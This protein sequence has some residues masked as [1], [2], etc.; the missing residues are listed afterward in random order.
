M[1]EETIEQQTLPPENTLPDGQEPAKDQSAAPS[2]EE[3]AREQGWN[4]DYT[5]PDRIDAAE[6]VRRK[7][8]FD[9][10]R[11]QSRELREIKQSV[12]AMAKTYKSMSEA[13]YRRGIA[14]AAKRMDEAE[15]TY[16]VGAY[17]EALKEKT[18][19]EAAQASV[20]HTIPEGLPPEVADF[21]NRNPWFDKDKI[22][23][24]DALEYKD[25]YIKRNP[26]APLKDVLLYVEERIKRDYPEKFTREKA[27]TSPPP[28]VPT[29]ETGGPS[30]PTTNDSLA[31]L[32]ASLTSEEKRV[33]KMFVTP[34]GMTEAE[35][36]KSYAEVRE[37]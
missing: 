37:L 1:S 11:L 12:D 10:I 14:D 5:G 9:K 6:F 4:P 24:V 21:C 35:Y 15:A 3:T 30:T 7:P 28:K 36:L 33:M 2:I 25:R 17:K 8:L 23:Q 34:G 29:V 19:L 32:K 31:K 20:S 22:M 18:E 16:N 27:P 26:N 13:Q